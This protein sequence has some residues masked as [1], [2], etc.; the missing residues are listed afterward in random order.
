VA[1]LASSACTVSGVVLRAAGGRFSVARWE[2]GHGVD[3]GSVP[4]TPDDIAH[5]WEDISSG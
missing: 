5:R 1:F 4:A 3:L 2:L